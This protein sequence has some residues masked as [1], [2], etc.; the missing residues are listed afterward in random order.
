[1]RDIEGI[2]GPSV[3]AS[4]LDMYFVEGHFLALVQVVMSN[5]RK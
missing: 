2:A 5:L 4:L 1:M 3:V